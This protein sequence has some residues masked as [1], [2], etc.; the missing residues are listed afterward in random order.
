MEPDQ[1]ALHASSLGA[2]RRSLHR[3]KADYMGKVSLGC[4]SVFT[5]A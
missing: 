3:T 4:S 1:L 5:L 2:A